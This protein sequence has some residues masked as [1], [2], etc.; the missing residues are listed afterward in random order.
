DADKQ[1]YL[2]PLASGEHVWCQLFSEPSAGSDVAGLRTR[3]EKKGDDWI[4]NGQKVWTTGAHFSDY[5]IVITRTDPT[6][7]KHKGL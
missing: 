7:P 2:P 6:Q 4:I 3:A 1:K 5:G